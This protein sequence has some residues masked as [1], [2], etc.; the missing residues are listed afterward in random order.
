MPGTLDFRWDPLELAADQTYSTTIRVEITRWWEHEAPGQVS[1]SVRQRGQDVLPGSPTLVQRGKA[2]YPLIGLQ[3]KHHYLVVVTGGGRSVENMIRVP[4]L[5]EPKRP[6]Q[7]ALELE[8][9]QLERTKVYSERRKLAAQEKE[10]TLK[11]QVKVLHLYRR[12][13]RLEVVLQRTGKDGKPEDGKISVLDF[14]QGGVVFGNAPG[15]FLFREKKW[16]IVVFS[17]PYFE[18][19]RQATF[20]LP[21]DPDAE[22]VVDVPARAEKKPE[23]VKGPSLF[24]RMREA[25]FQ[26]RDKARAPAFEFK[27]KRRRPLIFLPDLPPEGQ[28]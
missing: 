11:R 25:Y 1:V 23:K 17:L 5:P 8:R 4:E 24:E 20:F 21:D 27:I 2:I 26:E 12:L 13:S 9:I 14:E 18:Y 19:P 16:G 10:P 7:E 6:E 3:P 15:D 28:D 22:V